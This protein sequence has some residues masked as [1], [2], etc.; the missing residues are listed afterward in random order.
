MLCALFGTAVALIY[1]LIYTL[2][3]V[4][5]VIKVLT[6]L[7]MV[8]LS[9]NG[10]TFRVFY[11]NALVFFCLTFLT[12]GAI[13]GAFNLLN[14]SY[15][16]EVFLSIAFIPAYF[17]IKGV[18][19]VIKYLYRQKEIVKAVYSVEITLGQRKVALKGFMDTG[20]GLYD[21]DRAV[22]IANKKTALD[23]LGG[24]NGVNLK[25]ITVRTVSGKRQNLAFE[26]DQ[27]KIY[28]GDKAN[29]HNKVTVCVT[30]TEIGDGYDLILHPAL[31]ENCDER[32]FC[33]IEKVC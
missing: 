29:I 25:R 1:P 20:N 22:V 33:E 31:T 3:I 14:I 26:I 7:V 18:T 4:S 10:K 13:V 23:I 28:I 5:V 6:G 8:L 30:P 21:G 11:I 19:A 15:S 32:S 2:T 12:G 17:V 27:I 24:F 9:V 16:S